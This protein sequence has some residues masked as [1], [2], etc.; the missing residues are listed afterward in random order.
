LVAADGSGQLVPCGQVVPCVGFVILLC[1]G[2][3]GGLVRWCETWVGLYH[4]ST[5][6]PVRM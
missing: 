2:L 3:G 4:C 5:V 1:V 6:G